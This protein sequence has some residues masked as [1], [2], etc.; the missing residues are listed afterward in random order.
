[1]TRPPGSEPTVRTR[2]AQGRLPAEVAVLAAIAFA[3]AIGFGIVAPVIPLYAREF[4]VG[5][6]L[7]GAVVSVF[8]GMRLVSGLLGGRLVDRFAERSVLTTG[9]LIVAVSSAL[10]GAAQSY[11]Q[12]LVMRGA[13]GVG[14]AMFTVSAFA[15][16]YRVVEPGLRGR[17]AGLIQGGFLLGGVAGPALGGLLAETSLRAPFFVYAVTL[18]VAAV[19]STVSLRHAADSRREQDGSSAPTPRTTL[20]TALRSRAYVAALVTQVGTGWALFGIRSSLIPLFVA[21]A[22]GL[23]TR[24]VGVGFV[25][26]AVVQ[27]AL[28]LPAGRFVDTVGR[29]PAMVGGGVVASGSVALLA[30]WPTQPGF[31]LAMALY[32]AGAALLGT[33]PAA[34]VGDVVG[35]RGGTVVAVSQMASDVGAILGPVVAGILVETGSYTL[36]F[37]VTAGVIA[38]GVLV[39]LTMPE[40]RPPRAR[41][42]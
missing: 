29:R 26:S 35:S 14:S 4:G 40:T 38:A 34:V 30:V 11:P 1:V 7:A 10:A 22:L 39:S 19:I 9:L 25:L 12:L 32:G 41:D 16:M 3:V 27:G 8:A 37:S 42:G 17:A 33:A 15:L 21:D 36:A 2:W 31:L 24:W 6:T 5:A 20:R 18:G 23:P 13:G 28:L